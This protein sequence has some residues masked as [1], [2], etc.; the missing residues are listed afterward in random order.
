MTSYIEFKHGLRADKYAEWS[1]DAINELWTYYEDDSAERFDPVAIRCEWSEYDLEELFEGY[2]Y[3]TAFEGRKA[4]SMKFEEW[5][6]FL[7]ELHGRLYFQLLPNGNY[8]T[9]EV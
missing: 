9:Q 7:D 3:M 2:A 1:T 6:I 5:E 8:L 4:N